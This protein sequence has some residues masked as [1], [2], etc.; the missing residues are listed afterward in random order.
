[1]QGEPQFIID[2][3]LKEFI[4]IQAKQAT[5]KQILSA[6]L[7]QAKAI[8]I[9]DFLNRKIA[10]KQLPNFKLKKA[11]PTVLV[12]IDDIFEYLEESFLTEISS[13]T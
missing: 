5:K 4:Q 13:N 8:G 9:V 1:M 10:A 6:F 11:F 3:V 2:P 7:E 12:N